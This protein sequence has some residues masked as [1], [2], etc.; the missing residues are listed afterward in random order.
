MN[1]EF[2][3]PVHYKGE[4]LVFTATLHNYGYSYKIHVDVYGIDVFFEPDEERNYRV[5]IGPEYL[6]GMNKIDIELL[7]AI[8]V[9]IE[10]AKK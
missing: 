2:D 3:I 6:E 10:S 1:E 7:K 5:V 9:T 4:D 8:S